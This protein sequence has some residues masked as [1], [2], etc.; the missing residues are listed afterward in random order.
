M[1]VLPQHFVDIISILISRDNAHLQD[2]QSAIKHP[3]TRST[4]EMAGQIFLADREEWV[5]LRATEMNCLSIT[6]DSFLSFA[7]VDVP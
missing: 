5:P 4:F 6:P 3:Y 7:L 2:L 1:L